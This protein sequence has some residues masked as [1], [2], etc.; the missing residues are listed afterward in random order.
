MTIAVIR[1]GADHKAFNPLKWKEG[2]D[3]EAE[4]KENKLVV[5]KT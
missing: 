3:L 5:K 1:I 4:V 2:Q